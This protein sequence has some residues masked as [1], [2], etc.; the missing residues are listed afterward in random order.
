MDSPQLNSLKEEET[1]AKTPGPYGLGK[2]EL[3]WQPCDDGLLKLEALPESATIASDET[4]VSL[5]SDPPG[6]I[7]LTSSG[8]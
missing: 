4:H 7:L 3:E 2:L 1:P 6:S 5:A 8:A